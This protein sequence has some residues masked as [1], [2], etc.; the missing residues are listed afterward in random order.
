MIQEQGLNFL[1]ALDL[2]TGCM[3]LGKLP[4]L[5]FDSSFLNGKMEIIC[6]LELDRE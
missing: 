1:T 2:N 4:N 3:V 6:F 5:F